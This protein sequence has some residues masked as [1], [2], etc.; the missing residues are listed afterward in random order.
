MK[1]FI[2]F[3]ITNVNNGATITGIE[4]NSIE[5]CQYVEKMIANSYGVRY[6]NCFEK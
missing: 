3:I 2:L 6:I 5:K 4:F 1:I